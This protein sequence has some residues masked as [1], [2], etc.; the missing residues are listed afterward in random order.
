[1]CQTGH[2]SADR[3]SNRD[4][5]ITG[6]SPW[7]QRDSTGQVSDSSGLFHLDRRGRP[8]S[9][10]VDPTELS[11]GHPELP[12]FRLDLTRVW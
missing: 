2:R 12:W 4:A 3:A 1:M 5:R 10:F 8:M 11:G 7:A 6:Q 9:T